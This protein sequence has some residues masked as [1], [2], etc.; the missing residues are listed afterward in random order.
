[1]NYLE[2]VIF[3]FGKDSIEFSNSFINLFQNVIITD[4][5]KKYLMRSDDNYF[6]RVQIDISGV[7]K[8]VQARFV[9]DDGKK[10]TIPIKNETNV[11]KESEE[12]YSH[13]ELKDLLNRFHSYDINISK[14]DHIGF[15]LPWFSEG[16][17][18]KIK[19]LRK[20]LYNKSLYHTF[21][22]GEPWD[23]ILPAKKEEINCSITT[24]YSLIRKPKIEL[25]SFEKCSIPIIQFDVCCTYSKNKFKTAFPEGIYDINLG[26]IWVYLKNPFNI[27]ICLVLNE[28]YEGDR[29]KYFE[30]SRLKYDNP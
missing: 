17:H 28:D 29:S 10:Y 3:S 14:I 1:M 26:N 5:N 8:K 6:P 9:L 12:K 22:S 20:I 13:L 27:D 30:N 24:D 2:D 7:K 21:P 23:F 19:K 11:T 18:P 16:I 25:V 15:N 4:N